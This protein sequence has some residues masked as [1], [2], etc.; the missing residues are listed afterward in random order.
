MNNNSN[1]PTDTVQGKTFSHEDYF[2]YK[3]YE[4]RFKKQAKKHLRRTGNFIGLGL[5]L[6][7]VFANA[8]SV[9]QTSLFS[10]IGETTVVKEAFYIIGS[11]VYVGVSFLITY[12]GVRKRERA[13]KFIPLNKP[14][15]KLSA[16]FIPVGVM[17]C[18]AASSVTGILVTLLSSVG[19]KLSQAEMSTPNT[20]VEIVLMFISTAVVPALMEELALRGIV[21]QSLRGYGT[22]FSMIASSA[23]FGIMHGNLIQAPFA[24][25]VGMVLGFIVVKTDSIWL[26]IVIHFINNSVSVLSLV[27]SEKWYGNFV[28]GAVMVVIYL[29]G[30]TGIIIISIMGKDIFQKSRGD[31]TNA[32]G[33][34][35]SSREKFVSTFINVPM[36][37]ALIYMLYVTSTYV[38]IG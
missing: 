33:R 36:I 7:I 22:L 26:G 30:I 34:I 9:L 29:A 1:I 18:M 25:A 28:I 11:I 12:L 32:E 21:L 4:R 19:V 37:L 5:V 6:Y 13:A 23:I 8:I 10:K 3:D 31:L 17:L 2:A 16:L 14:R 15:G 20:A 27:L 35:L 38:K 24:F